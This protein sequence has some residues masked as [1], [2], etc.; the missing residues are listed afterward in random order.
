MIYRLLSLTILTFSAGALFA[1]SDTLTKDL[2][3]LK[4]IG[5]ENRDSLNYEFVPNKI[6]GVENRAFLDFETEQGGASRQW[7]SLQMTE[8]FYGTFIDDSEK[9]RL[10]ENASDKLQLGS[11]QNWSF[12]FAY[13]GHKKR[14]LLPLTKRS[15][16]LFNKSYSTLSLS[17]DLL[18]LIL[19]GNKPTAGEAQDIS[20]FNYQSWF[21]SGFGHQYAF[22]ID[23]IPVSIGVGLVAMHTL[24]DYQTGSAKVTTAP[25]GSQIDFSGNYDLG[26]SGATQSYGVTGWGLAINLESEESRGPHN[27]RIGAYDLG[28]VY[29]DEW[30]NITRDSSFTFQGINLGSLFTL[31]EESLTNL[32]DSLADGL[33]GATAAG[34]WRMLPLRLKMR[35]RYHFQK[36]EY[37]YTEIDYLHL[38]NWFTRTEIGY[39]REY[40]K[41]QYQAG[42]AY[43]G[44][45]GISIGANIDWQLTRYWHL[46]G[47]L[48][49]V[50]GVVTPG[51]SG[52]TFGHF[53]LR[54]YL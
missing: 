32:A 12:R 40:T 47:G 54:Y 16:Y 30:Q 44:F 37:L 22:L 35:Y 14:K 25:D 27:L 24:D 41:W 10:L 29:M 5:S 31:T 33:V 9:L 15:F 26:N 23:T 42:L 45:N 43:G 6:F 51:L 19:L 1:Q 3:P 53:G 2:H 18:Q 39:G 48:T 52:G 7:N 8:F 50:L 49:N 11:I 17:P 46:R 36:E 21:Y 20:D 13:H 4:N 34:Q 38:P 28:A